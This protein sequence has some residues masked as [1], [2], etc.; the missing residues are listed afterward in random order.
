MRFALGQYQ[1]KNSSAYYREK[2]S[3][4][5]YADQRRAPRADNELAIQTGALAQVVPSAV[6]IHQSAARLARLHFAFD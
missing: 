2:S 4:W 3:P 5:L 6:V 1:L